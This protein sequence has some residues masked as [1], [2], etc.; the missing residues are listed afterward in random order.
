MQ[1]CTF[2]ESFGVSL[3]GIVMA[4]M[5]V[6]FDLIAL[7][8]VSLIMEAVFLI[9]G[10]FFTLKLLMEIRKKRSSESKL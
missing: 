6:F 2:L 8:M 1:I 9:L 10:Y 4:L 7:A 5:F 3:F